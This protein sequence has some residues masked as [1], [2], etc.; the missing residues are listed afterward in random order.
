MVQT[1]NHKLLEGNIKNI[2][3]GFLNVRPCKISV[4]YT[5]ITALIAAFCVRCRKIWRCK[6]FDPNVLFP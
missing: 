6:G 2:Y 1:R 4:E 5:A 3:H